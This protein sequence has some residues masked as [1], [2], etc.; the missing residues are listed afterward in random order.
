MSVASLD[1]CKELYA[2]SDWE[3]TE[4]WWI[5]KRGGETEAYTG[6]ERS[7]YTFTGDVDLNLPAY[8]LG[9]LWRKLPP[10]INIELAKRVH[11]EDTNEWSVDLTAHY[12]D[13]FYWTED[14]PTVE[15][16][17]ASLLIRLIKDKDVK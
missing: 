6:A 8:D 15:D 9:Y 12:G 11:Y 14:F 17:L 4:C 13:S 7:E 2:L 10:S 1:L 3:D 16:A 5:K